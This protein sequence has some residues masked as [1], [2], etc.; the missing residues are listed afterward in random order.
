ML[1]QKTPTGLLLGVFLCLFIAFAAPTSARADA[2]HSAC[3]P[4]R[5]G[6]WVELAAVVDGD[7]L[8]L[9]DGR[10]VRVL[11]INAPEMGRRGQPGQPFSR[12]ATRE[13]QAF[14]KGVKRLR[15]VI[16]PERE[17]RYGRLLANVYR[18]DG[19]NLE[20]H[21]LKKGL[22][23]H[24]PVPPNLAQAECYAELEQVAR[25]ERLG[26]WGD[27]GFTAIAARDVSTGGYQRVR[28]R[29]TS[30]DFRHSWWLSLD[31]RFTVAIYPIDQARF[32]RDEIARWQGQEVEIK[33][34]VFAVN[35]QW[36]MKLETP[37]VIR[38]VE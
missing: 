13:A 35:G 30:V 34:W 27:R 22:A 38:T 5:N 8:R 2:S 3:T 29:V 15:L 26:I 28:G 6:E 9:K 23:F 7:T 33:G 24:A 32:H 20:E 36:R 31:D 19:T 4:L 12:V 18:P 37:W 17:D 14:F 21:L 25:R 16:G 1:H 11:S 10:S